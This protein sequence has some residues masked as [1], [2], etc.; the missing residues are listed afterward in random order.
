MNNLINTTYAKEE[1]ILDQAIADAEQACRDKLAEA[2]MAEYGNRPVK[3][4]VAGG[5]EI[6]IITSVRV[7]IPE[8]CK[9]GIETYVYVT[10][11]NHRKEYMLGYDNKVEILVEEEEEIYQTGPWP[12]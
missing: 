9:E 11:E 1:E 3:A 2:V 5:P 12:F 7:S 8:Q 4:F 10:L 6:G